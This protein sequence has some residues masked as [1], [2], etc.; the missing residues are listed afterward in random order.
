MLLMSHELNS[1]TFSPATCLKTCCRVLPEPLVCM[2]SVQ[3]SSV[4]SR[5]LYDAV[6]GT[7]WAVKVTGRML[8]SEPGTE[9]CRVTV[10]ACVTTE[11]GHHLYINTT[12]ACICPGATW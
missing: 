10:L 5:K 9:A 2:A 8:G 3:A 1:R 4:Q 12:V 6:D 7:I 11:T